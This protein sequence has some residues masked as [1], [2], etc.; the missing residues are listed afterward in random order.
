MDEIF[1]FSASAMLDLS[2]NGA[3]VL[4]G[5]FWTPQSHT[6]LSLGPSAQRDNI[7]SKLTK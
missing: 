4:R 6:A 3:D 1:K 7:F 2:I 5:H